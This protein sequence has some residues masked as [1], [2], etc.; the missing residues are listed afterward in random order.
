[1]SFPD[2]HNLRLTRRLND[3]SMVVFSD[4]NMSLKEAVEDGVHN[5][6]GVMDIFKVEYSGPY[7]DPRHMK[8]VTE[9]YKMLYHGMTHDAKPDIK[10]R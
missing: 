8:D 1:M 9:N 10:R 4:F 2:W 5:N 6:L 3:G 7:A